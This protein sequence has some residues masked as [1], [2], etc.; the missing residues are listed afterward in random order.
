MRDD[1]ARFALVAFPS[2]R[3]NGRPTIV[4]ITEDA[5]PAAYRGLMPPPVT[6]IIGVV[7]TRR[8]Q[9]QAGPGGI[10]AALRKSRA[11]LNFS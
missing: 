11:C 4:T 1:G 10:L 7:Q 9:G 6:D 2:A 8:R 5:L 3:A